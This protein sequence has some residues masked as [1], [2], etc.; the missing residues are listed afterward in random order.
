MDGHR[1]LENIESFFPHA[2]RAGVDFLGS[3]LAI[4]DKA[5]DLFGNYRTPRAGSCHF[6]R[7]K[8]RLIGKPII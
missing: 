4:V 5:A 8:Q 2:I 3:I 6:L 1:L 7:V